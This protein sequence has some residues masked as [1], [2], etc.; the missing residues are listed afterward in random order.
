MMADDTSANAIGIGIMKVKMFDG[1]VRALV[2]VR[3]VPQLRRSLI[4]SGTLDTLGCEY[5]TKSGFMEV[6]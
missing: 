2:N 5:S 1:V 3:H 4:S 6:S